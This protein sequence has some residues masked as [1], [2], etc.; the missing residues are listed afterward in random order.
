MDIMSI[1][2]L[3]GCVGFI[4]Y[5]IMDSGVINNFFDLPSIVIVVGGTFTA[6]MITFPLKVFAGLPKQLLKIFVPQKFYPLS[7]ISDIVTIATDVRKSGILSQEDKISD[8]KDEFLR[9]GL[10]L[11]VDSTETDLLRDIMETELMFMIDRHKLGISFFEKGAALAPGFGMIGTLIGLINM[12]AGMGDGGDI[13]ALVANMGV[14]LVTTFYGSMLANVL[15]L[16]IANKLMQRSDDEVLC[17][18]IVIE[19]LISIKNGESPK[20]IEEKL[21]SYIPPAMRTAKGKG[22]ASA[23]DD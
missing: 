4:F 5:G 23:R 13:N 9:K 18:Q 6:L 20:P 21:L 14:A 16:P 1:I 15:F 7:Y 17:K 8:Y 10:Q 19:G 3:I 11:A 2:G 12:L 22:G